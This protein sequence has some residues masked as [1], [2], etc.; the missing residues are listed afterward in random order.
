MNVA[1]WRSYLDGAASVLGID[2]LGAY[3]FGPAIDAAQGHASYFWQAGRQSDVRTQT[4][5]YQ[6]N[7]GNTTLTRNQRQAG[8]L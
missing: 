8:G 7:N 1:P 6:W 4:H 3:G 5:I 2:R